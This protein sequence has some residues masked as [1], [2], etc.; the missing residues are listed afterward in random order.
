MFHSIGS[1][2]IRPY[3][4]SYWA[5]IDFRFALALEQAFRVHQDPGGPDQRFLQ[6]REGEEQDSGRGQLLAAGD[7]LSD[8]VE[9]LPFQVTGFYHRTQ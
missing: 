8:K 1:C 3:Y 5:L 7:V 6:G 2:A 9:V 4:L